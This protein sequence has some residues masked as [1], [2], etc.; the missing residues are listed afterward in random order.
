MTICEALRRLDL[1]DS[2][3]QHKSGRA[4]YPELLLVTTNKNRPD[5]II[6]ARSIF[7]LSRTCRYL[8]KVTSPSLLKNIRLSPFYSISP[9]E[10]GYL[11]VIRQ[12]KSLHLNGDQELRHVK[13]LAVAFSSRFSSGDGDTASKGELRNEIHGLLRRLPNLRHLTVI[14]LGL[15]APLMQSIPT[16]SL[17]HLWLWGAET[18]E[19]VANDSLTSM[20]E[21]A[22]KL[23]SLVVRESLQRGVMSIPPNWISRLIGPTMQDLAVDGDVLNPT[24]LPNLPGLE[25]LEVSSGSRAARIGPSVLSMLSKTPNL[26]EVALELKA[27]PGYPSNTFPTHSHLQRIMCHSSWLRYL[28]PGSSVTTAKVLCDSRLDLQ[29]FSEILHEGN[30]PLRNL[31][32]TYTSVWPQGAWSPDDLEQV[33]RCFP[34]LEIFRFRMQDP[35]VG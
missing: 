12:V 8:R 19:R 7:Q 21:P 30:V 10:P 25:F 31:S 13:G 16:L 2:M 22:L 4:L 14:R 27:P 23:Q 17:E 3:K 24:N 33:V 29:E 1:I 34:E 9:N 6:T 11:S 5:L 32:L 18:D 26:K 28:I 15:D 20:T 35:K